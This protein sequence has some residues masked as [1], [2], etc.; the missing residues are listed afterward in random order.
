MLRIE[1]SELSRHVHKFVLRQ[2][3]M[4]VLGAIQKFVSN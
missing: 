3:L 2:T 1:T 4:S